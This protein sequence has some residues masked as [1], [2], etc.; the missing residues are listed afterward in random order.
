[1]GSRETYN[2]SPQNTHRTNVLS[3]ARRGS[4]NPEVVSIPIKKSPYLK[5]TTNCRA[6]EASEQS[7]Q[8]DT[9]D[10]AATFL[11]GGSVG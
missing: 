1:M 9:K 3:A 2:R 10:K 4:G 5:S 8:S 7:G 6:A 11:A